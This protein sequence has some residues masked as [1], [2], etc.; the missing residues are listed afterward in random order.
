MNF[1]NHTTRFVLYAALLAPVLSCKKDKNPFPVFPKDFS[2]ELGAPKD[3]PWYDSLNYNTAVATFGIPPGFLEVVLP[4]AKEDRGWA[5][6]PNYGVTAVAPDGAMVASAFAGNAGVD[7]TYL[8]FGPFNVESGS[9]VE[10]SFDVGLEFNEDP[11]SVTFKFSPDYPGN[12]NPEEDEITWTNIDAVNNALP[13]ANTLPYPSNY[14]NPATNEIYHIA[15]SF[16]VGGTNLIYVA[17]HFKDGNDKDSKRW[18][19]DNLWLKKL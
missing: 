14:I 16:A 15:G 12:G 13:T 4:G 5:F 17:M 3:L 6:R 7:N 1:F 9:T 2:G 19:F 8:I 18:R 11:G 10:L